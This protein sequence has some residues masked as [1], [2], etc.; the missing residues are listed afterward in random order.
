M[1][2]D[3]LAL[4]RWHHLLGNVVRVTSRFGCCRPS[5]A[6]APDLMLKIRQVQQEEA[7]DTYLEEQGI[8]V[9]R[10]HNEFD[11]EDVIAEDIDD[12]TRLLE[13]EQETKNPFVSLGIGYVVYMGAIE[14][15]ALVFATLLLF[16]ISMMIAFSVN[17]SDNTVFSLSGAY[18]FTLASQGVNLPVCYQ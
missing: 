18:E 10:A 7:L 13:A 12:Q 8:K 5:P 4:T 14:R 11:Q 15:L 1:I 9:T 2:A 17:Q 3:Y 16:G 6:K